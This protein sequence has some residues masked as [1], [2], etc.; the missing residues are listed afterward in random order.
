M[1]DK[2][3]GVLMWNNIHTTLDRL[4]DP[5]RLRPG[6]GCKKYCKDR[7]LLQRRETITP[8]IHYT[9]D[10]RQGTNQSDPDA[11]AFRRFMVAE[12]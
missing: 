2:H 4:L 6:R 9:P 12:I 8:D 10:V 11:L 5:V 3:S 7:D 1:Q